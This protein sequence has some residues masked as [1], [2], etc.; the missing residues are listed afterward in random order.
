MNMIDLIREV[1]GR[2]PKKIQNI[3]SQIDSVLGHRVW[4]PQEGPQTTAYFSAADELFYGGAAGGGKTDLL[5]GLASTAHSRALILR[6][7]GTDLGAIEE[8]LL[9]MWRSRD[10]YNGQSRIMRRDGRFIEL[11]SCPHEKDK[12]SY[13]G[14]PHDLKAFD[15]IT[16]FSESI[17]RYVIAWN[18]TTLPGQRC[19]IVCAGN[20]P[21][22]PEG[23]WVK[24]YWAPWLDP[25]HRNP[26]RPGELRYFS[27]DESSG[28][29]E[30]DS[31][32][33]GRDSAG[34]ELKPV[35]RTFVPACLAD[36]V[37]L[38][39]DY[40]ARIASMPEPYRTQLLTGSFTAG[41]KDHPRQLIP[42]RW[43]ELAQ[44]RWD[45]REKARNL[46]QSRKW[47]MTAIGCDPALGGD[48]EFV[49]APIYDNVT[50]G[51]LIS[52]PGKE[53]TSGPAGAAL[54]IQYHRDQARLVIDM[55]GGYGE[56]VV[57]HLVGKMP[58]PPIGYKGGRS[59]HG[60]S[61]SGLSFANERTKA[62][63][64]FREALDPDHPENSGAE[65]AIPRDE[66]LKADLAALTFEVRGDTIHAEPKEK[67]C[68]RLGRSTDRGDA[69]IMAFSAPPVTQA[70]I[71]ALEGNRITGGSRRPVVVLGYQKSKRK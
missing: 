54:I 13:Q 16:Q 71:K 11:G 6:R 53:I 12:Y 3:E 47:V 20:P 37:Y 68:A 58:L 45:D 27:S 56:G 42:T 40:R 15:E 22:T 38:G 65:I 18:R 63:W 39:A 50:I 10:G 46:G 49:L 30:V 51:E 69:V 23:D 24:R 7:E 66:R 19:R 35:S 62:Y 44:S 2:D 8:R 60:K 64:Q 36:N 1:A 41:V 59:A 17:Y 28:D 25:T 43:I 70:D 32:W 52:V 61:R 33:R 21:S 14:Q 34:N 29:L 55:G 4:Y 67:V 57:S 48:D 9:E 31:D 5:L 26:A